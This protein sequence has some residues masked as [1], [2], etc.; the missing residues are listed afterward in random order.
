MSAIVR[1]A[2]RRFLED[3]GA[4]EG[5]LPPRAW[6]EATGPTIARLAATGASVATH[7]LVDAITATRDER[8]GRR[9]RRS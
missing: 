6:I 3:A 4:H 8:S 9:P 5:T 1:E 7:A 2:V